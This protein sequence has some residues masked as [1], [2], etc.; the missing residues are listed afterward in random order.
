MTTTI[1]TINTEKGLV[2]LQYSVQVGDL[3][4]C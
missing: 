3:G 2:P 4:F 1:H